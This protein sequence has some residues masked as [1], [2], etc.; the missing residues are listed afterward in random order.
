MDHRAR[1]RR[2][3]LGAMLAALCGVSL[4]AFGA[5]GEPDAATAEMAALLRDIASKIDPMKLPILVDDRRAELMAE[6]LTWPRPSSERIPMRAAYAAALLNAGRIDDCLAALD[7][8]EQDARQSAPEAW[9]VRHNLAVMQRAVA[10]MRVAE[11]QNCHLA[12]TPDSCLL[13]IRGEGVHKRREG[14]E[15]AAALFEAVL[16]EEPGQLEA[17]WLLNVAHMT[18][19]SYPEG[20]PAARLIP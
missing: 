20:V 2:S 8:L 9:K 4:L 7:A 1:R 14:A 16:Q 13:P 19:G 5:A 18:L 6:Q 15:R 11:E 17:R 3:P 12:S 10:Y